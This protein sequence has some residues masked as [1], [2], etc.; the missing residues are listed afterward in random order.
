MRLKNLFLSFWAG[1][2]LLALADGDGGRGVVSAMAEELAAPPTDR[3]APPLVLGQGEQRLLRIPGLA[4]FALGSPCIRT[5]ALDS[6]KNALLIK[7]ICPGYGDLWISKADGSSEHRSIRV[8]KVAPGELTPP[9]ERAL[10]HLEEVEVLMAGSGVV[11]RGEITTVRESARIRAL[12]ETYKEVH[13]ETSPSD[14]LLAQAKARIE[15]WIQANAQASGLMIEKQGQQLFVRGSLERPSLQLTAEKQLRAI[16][17]G[18]MLELNTMPDTSPTV[19][20]RVFLLELKKS[21]FHS[22]GLT[23]PA[24]QEGAFRVTSAGIQDALGLDVALQALETEGSAK[25]LSN[26]ELVVRAPGEAELFA[27]GEIPIKSKSAYSSNVTWK[28]YGLTLHLKVTHSSGER[29]RLDIFT[30]VSHLDPTIAIDD[31]P[32]IQTNRMKTQVDARYG[33]PLLLSGLLQNGMR[34]QARGLPFLR[35]LPILG[36]LFG[37]EDYLNERSELVA[38]LLPASAPPEAPMSRVARF[39]P[40]GAVPAPRQW[41]SPEKERSLKA[42]NEWPWN[43]L[44]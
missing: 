21:R 20:F 15:A 30:E 26:P 29:V 18:V 38:I 34:E 9:L 25:L 36:S 6:S 40:R 3:E 5:H 7:G 41:L 12:T 17:P 43:A 44:K 2:G 28:N 4:R 23:W 22:F 42:S 31:I 35:R 24:M 27:G 37:S 16:F 11:L 14:E 19:H 8:E 39:V 13:D 10:G 1:I 32:G 33:V